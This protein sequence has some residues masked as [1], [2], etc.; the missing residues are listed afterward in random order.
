[1]IRVR[2]FRTHMQSRESLMLRW[3]GGKRRDW[4]ASDDS[5]WRK[6]NKKAKKIY[7]QEV[8]GYDS[9][10][11]CDPTW[12]L[13]LQ[14][15]QHRK[16]FRHQ[17]VKMLSKK[18]PECTCVV[19]VELFLLQKGDDT[20]W[21]G[22]E[23]M[24][25]DRKVLTVSQFVDTGTDHLLTVCG[26]LIDRLNCGKRQEKPARWIV[27]KWRSLTANFDFVL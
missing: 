24:G 27:K 14:L 11:D 3:I 22:L 10:A 23:G 17:S 1:M 5:V 7:I 20:K 8:I 15:F 13:S 26:Q 18:K 2:L 25:E 21:S 12:L 9:Y 19:L 6:Q 4:R 16:K